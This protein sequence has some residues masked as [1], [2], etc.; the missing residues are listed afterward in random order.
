MCKKS[1]CRLY[2]YKKCAG[3]PLFRGESSFTRRIFRNYSKTVKRVVKPYKNRLQG[4][5]KPHFFMNPLSN[6]FEPTFEHAL[7]TN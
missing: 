7:N 2:Y 4:H 5:L 6:Y 1:R 3:L